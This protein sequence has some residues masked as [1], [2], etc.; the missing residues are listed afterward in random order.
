MSQIIYILALFQI[1]AMA[2]PAWA[3]EADSII[4]FWNTPDN[5]AQFEIYRCGTLYCGK[6]SYLREPNYPPTDKSM[7]GRPILDTNNPDPALRDRTLTGLPLISGFSYQGDNSW[8]GMIY[9]PKDGN[10]YRCNFSMAGCDRLKV[11]GYIGIPLFGMTQ[12][13]TRGCPE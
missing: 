7:P 4:G 9:N 5:K 6:I 10:T 2:A 1:I 13:W 11:R 12:V 3:V 8:E